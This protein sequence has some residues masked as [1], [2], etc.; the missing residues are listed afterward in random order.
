MDKIRKTKPYFQRIGLLIVVFYRYCIVIPVRTA[1][2]IHPGGYSYL[3]LDFRTKVLKIKILYIN[4]YC[5]FIVITIKTI[6]NGLNS[7]FLWRRLF[8]KKVHFQQAG[9]PVC[10]SG[11]AFLLLIIAP[12]ILISL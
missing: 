6:R 5:K 9:L 12:G 8:S 7:V 1:E 4:L 2:T 11:Q 10:L 3:R